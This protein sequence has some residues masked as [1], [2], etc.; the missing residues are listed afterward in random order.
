MRKKYELIASDV[1]G[2]YRVKALTDFGNVKAGDV[3][4]YVAGEHNLSHDGN[5][6]VYGDARVYGNARVYGDAWVYGNARVYD[7]A[8]IYGGNCW[9]YGDARVYGNACV[10]GYARV[11]GDAWVYGDARVYGDAC[12]S[13]Y[14]RVRGDA[15]V[16][17][18][19]T[20]S[21]SNDYFIVGPALS[22]G[23]YTTAHKTAEGYQ[24]NCG[25]YTTDSIEEFKKRVKGVHSG[26]N[27]GSYLVIVASLDAWVKSKLKREIENANS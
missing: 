13:G 27:L 7:N 19:A 21:N 3:G 18:Y 4:G 20:I 11:R 25:C 23:R 5:C 22:S 15:C 1:D 17:G 26:E 10:S 14:A 9:V 6:W 2:L 8:R 12:V 24:I 16:S